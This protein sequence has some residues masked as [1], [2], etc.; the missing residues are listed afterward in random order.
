MEIAQLLNLEIND[1][2]PQS[3]LEL[4][5]TLSRINNLRVIKQRVHRYLRHKLRIFQLRVPTLNIVCYL[6]LDYSLD[7]RLADY[8]T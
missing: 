6:L 8:R 3:L 2:H 5:L 7:I 4:A 1:A